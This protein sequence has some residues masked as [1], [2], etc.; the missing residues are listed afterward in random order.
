MY[1]YKIT[2][3]YNGTNYFGWQVQP[4]QLTVQG[5]LNS[6]LT[7]VCKSSNIKTLGSGRTDAGVH[8][9]EQIV[10]VDIP[11]DIEPESLIRAINSNLPRDVR[12]IAAQRCDEKFMPT[13]DALWKEYTYLFTNN[14]FANSFQESFI[15][16]Y[17]YELDFE[18]MDKGCRLLIGKHD[19][20]NFFCT[21]TD[22]NSTVR[23]IYLA[24]I[25]SVDV[26]GFIGS[27][28]PNHYSFTIRGSGFLKQMVRLI[29]GSL[30]N[31]GRGKITLEQ[32]SD[33]LERPQKNKL[34]IVAPASGL[35]LARVKY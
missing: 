31:V 17:P 14:R 20:C 23:E 2:L 1:Y 16:N 15:A 27:V 29:I 4:D 28:F 24:S 7:K 26:N 35:Y 25:Q 13:V 22:V 32:L 8:A 30:W 19:F 10:K 9:L 12:C 18:K 5:V 11:I 34:G 6:S 3:Q 33:A 21:G